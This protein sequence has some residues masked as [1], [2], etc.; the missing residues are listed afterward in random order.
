MIR[1]SLVV[2]IYN[3]SSYLRRCLDSIMCQTL[4]FDEII[5]VDDGSTDNSGEIADEYA[6]AYHTVRVIHQ[7][8]AGLSAARNAGIDAAQGKYIAFVD[9]DDYIDHEMNEQLFALLQTC[10]ANMVKG[11]VW[12]EQENGEKYTPYPENQERIWSTEEA[13][14][15]LN[16]YRYFNMSAWGGIFERQLFEDDGSGRGALRFPVGKLCE[17]YYLMHRIIARADKV[18][19]TSKPFYHYIQRSNSISRNK[20]VNM[21]PMDASLAQLSFFKSNFPNLVYV[22]ETAVAFSHM[23]IYSA[24]LRQGI[25]CPKDLLAH[26]RS[27]CRKYLSSVLRNSHIPGIK[28]FQALAFCYALPIY[29]LIIKRT[30]HR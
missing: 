30:I 10:D 3:V 24:H 16:S 13:L 2:P 17:D 4:P 18:A 1:L 27:I 20:K 9:S 28:K 15:E 12:Y 19:Y 11:G 14:I 29:T 6:S 8:N 5:L 21:A 26:L 22:A 25:I 23:G 7:E